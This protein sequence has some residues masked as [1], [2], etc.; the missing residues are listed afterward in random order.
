MVLRLLGQF[1]QQRE[2]EFISLGTSK[3]IK[4]AGV[5]SGKIEIR[6]EHRSVLDE[7]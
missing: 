1:L 4:P 5:C 3:T 6:R 7:L 2:D